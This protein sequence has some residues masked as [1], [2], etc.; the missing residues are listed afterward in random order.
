MYGTFGHN[1]SMS[2]GGAV[3]IRGAT[4]ASGNGALR[5][6]DCPRSQSGARG[7]AGGGAVSLGN[8]SL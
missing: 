4:A 7:A 6:N 1:S 2:R 5:A 3:T 8:H